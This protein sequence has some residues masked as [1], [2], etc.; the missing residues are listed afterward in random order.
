MKTHSAPAV[1]RRRASDL[2]WRLAACIVALA[3]LC[4]ALAGAQA[5]YPA[6]PVRIVVPYAVGGIADTFSRLLAVALA[7]STGQT[8]V[9]DNRPG[10]NGLVGS[11]IVAEAA[12][13]AARCSS[14]GSIRT[15]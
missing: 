9:T 3:V 5:P 10:G 7:E 6:K 1:V 12:P 4:P 14:A 2:R 8:V 15:G 13:D 11:D